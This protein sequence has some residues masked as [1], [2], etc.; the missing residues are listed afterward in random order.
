MD[1][2]A[3]L[4]QKAGVEQEALGSKALQEVQIVTSLFQHRLVQDQSPM[5]DKS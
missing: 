4:A 3:E 2:S 1:A 5:P